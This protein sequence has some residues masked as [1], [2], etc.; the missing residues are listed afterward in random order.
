MFPMCPSRSV[1]RAR[2]ASPSSASSAAMLR[3]LRMTTRSDPQNFP[4]SRNELVEPLLRVR[5]GEGY[6]QIGNQSTFGELVEYGFEQA[7][8]GAE[9]VVD[10]HPHDVR[11]PRHRIDRELR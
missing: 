1:S 3:S 6:A 5:R 11:A 10:R 7:A 2:S 9:L 8:P 4:K